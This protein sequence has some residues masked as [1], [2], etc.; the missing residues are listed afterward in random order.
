MLGT[1]L[2]EA[3]R[4]Y[5]R[6]L[7]PA[8]LEKLESR[9]GM[10]DSVLSVIGWPEPTAASL[11]Y[12][13]QLAEAARLPAFRGWEAAGRPPERLGFPESVDRLDDSGHSPAIVA[14]L[15]S[16]LHPEVS[17]WYLKAWMT[18]RWL[19]PS[20]Q[21]SP[22][23]VPMNTEADRRA[24][25]HVVYSPLVQ[26]EARLWAYAQSEG[27]AEPVPYAVR[28][29]LALFF[30]DWEVAQASMFCLRC[31]SPV[32]YRR[33]VR[34]GRVRA[35]RCR[36]CGPSQWPVHAQEPYDRGRWL[37]SCQHPDC[38]AMFVASGQARFCRDH[39]AENITP[40]RRKKLAQAGRT[41]S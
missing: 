30:T 10:R 3:G 25:C 39:R 11:N 23:N 21:T 34:S 19:H 38:A 16:V 20:T 8:E 27:I 12:A 26:L 17:S 4:R 37:L 35:G 13:R 14:P 6:E 28:Y 1:F 22:L 9:L 2:G 40:L 24:F 15:S 31:G 18:G 29:G 33:A 7:S 41:T 5:G 36:A 32:T